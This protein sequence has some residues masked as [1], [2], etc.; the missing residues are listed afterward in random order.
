MNFHHSILWIV[1]KI[2]GSFSPPWIGIAVL[3]DGENPEL[4]VFVECEN[5]NA[6]E[7]KRLA[8][9][10]LVADIGVHE[11]LRCQ[12]YRI[13]KPIERNLEGPSSLLLGQPFQEHQV[14]LLAP[15]RNSERQGPRIV[16]EIIIRNELFDLGD[17]EDSEILEEALNY[18]HFGFR[19]RGHCGSECVLVGALEK[20]SQRLAEHFKA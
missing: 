7:D 18:R 9:L 1:N 17:I 11:N 20:E 4:V 8:L 6:L 15:G 19:S 16:D 13:G 5:V 10:R 14:L 2:T 12:F 3:K